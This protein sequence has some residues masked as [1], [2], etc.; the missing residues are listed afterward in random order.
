[1]GRNG[2]FHI[3]ISYCVRCTGGLCDTRRTPFPKSEA[4]VFAL[5]RAFRFASGKEF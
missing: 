5:L 3:R 1:V 4:R 2:L